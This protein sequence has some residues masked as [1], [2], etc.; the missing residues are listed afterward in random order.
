MENFL[1]QTKSFNGSFFGRIEG[2]EIIDVDILLFVL[3]SDERDIEINVRGKIMRAVI[4][5][6]YLLHIFYGIVNH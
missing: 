5:I 2:E 1:S 3:L 6:I 4:N